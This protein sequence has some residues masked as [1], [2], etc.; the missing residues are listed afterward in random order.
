MQ[1]DQHQQ[2]I[3]ELE[4]MKA[5]QSTDLLKHESST[6]ALEA[7]KTTRAALHKAEID[8]LQQ[9]LNDAKNQE[10]ESQ[11]LLEHRLEAMKAALEAQSSCS[12]EAALKAELMHSKAMTDLQTSFQSQMVHFNSQIEVSRK[13][14]LGLSFDLNAL[15]LVCI[16]LFICK[17]STHS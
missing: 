2:A 15:H 16:L 11:L 4:E 13:P 1:L 17:A 5:R 9:Q 14:C 12:R 6:A 8:K 7:E 3:T 10:R